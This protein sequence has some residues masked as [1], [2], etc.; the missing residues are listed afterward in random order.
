MV[1]QTIQTARPRTPFKQVTASRGKHVR[2]EPFSALYENGKVRHAGQFT[3]LEGELTGFNTAGYVGEGSPNRADAC[4]WALAELFPG[5][6]AKRAEPKE[7]PKRREHV[8]AG[9]WMG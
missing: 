3:Q 4:I 5:L 6:V 8:G 7:A 9:G 2:A 1:G